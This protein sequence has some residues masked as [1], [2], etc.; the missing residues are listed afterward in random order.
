M[1]YIIIT[2]GVMSGLGKGITC[3]SIGVLLVNKGFSVTA[4]KIDPYIN[5]DAGTMN[6]FQHG[7]VFVLKDGGEAD[8]DLGNYERFL[9]VELTRDNNLT[10]GKIYYEVINNERAGTYLGKTV[11]IIP[12]ITD[13]I[14]K[15]IRTVAKDSGAEIC[16]IEVGG[17]VGDIESMPFLEAVRQLHS[18]EAEEDVFFAHVTL[19][20]T[21]PQ[22]EQKT[23]P[24]QHSVRELRELG[25]HPDCIVAR[26]SR[27]LSD[28]IKNKIA[29]FC[30]VTKEA[31][32]S[33]ND[34]E[35]IYDV[36]LMLDKGM[37]TYYL[38][39]KINLTPK[40]NL[41]EWEELVTKM[42]SATKTTRI[43]VVGKY[44][45]VKDS[46]LSIRE[47]LK[48]AAIHNNCKVD[49]KWV[50]A[51]DIERGNAESLLSDVKGIL[52]PGGFGQRGTQ[53]KIEAITYARENDVP[54]LGLCLGMQLAVI[55]FA[56]N[57]AGIVD[58]GSGEFRD[59]FEEGKGVSA[60]SCTSCD[61]GYVAGNFVI[62]I[63][64]EQEDLTDMGGTMR[65][66]DYTTMLTED[67]LA[68]RIYQAKEIVERHRHRYE[69][70]PDYVEILK[71]HGLVF[72]GIDKENPRRM[73][74]IELPEHKFFIACQAHPEF[75]SRP[76]KPA[77]LFREFVR[78]AL[79]S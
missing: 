19:V 41:Y 56:R 53:G 71:E 67:T 74:V 69:V 47:A 77:P 31:V 58:A 33:A 79:E 17:T 57:V 2:G 51:E 4:I 60:G 39:N 40:K 50:D 52:V 48:H 25:L 20:P 61:P 66:G 37:L 43:A 24:T 21:D 28:D 44:M 13:K 10:T 42:K 63:L 70:N 36:P 62:D 49:V 30:D 75:K 26:C 54:F 27:P 23:K 11:Q 6:P 7:E 29:L 1:K 14:K 18:E 68:M 9:N 15:K 72:S 34:A 73:E 5:V 3:A 12:H 8:L 32:I 22:G 45:E 16:L 38:L 64:P 55:E 46:Y 65:L 76:I 59:N 35:D 78:A